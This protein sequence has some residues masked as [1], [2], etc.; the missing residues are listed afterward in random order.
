MS[1]RKIV[2]LDYA[3]LNKTGRR[4]IVERKRVERKAT[5]MG[6][7][8]LQTRALE[9]SSDVADLFESY[10]LENMEDIGELN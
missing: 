9:I 2:H 10:D 5:K 1:S 7:N 4:V 6:D 3:E 8:E